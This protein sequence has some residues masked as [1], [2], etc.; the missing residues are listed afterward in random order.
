MRGS[1]SEE[2]IGPWCL[3]ICF[4]LNMRDSILFV[5]SVEGMDIGRKTVLMPLSDKGEARIEESCEML[6]YWDSFYIL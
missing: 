4:K 5:S 1:G 2:E 6:V 3:M